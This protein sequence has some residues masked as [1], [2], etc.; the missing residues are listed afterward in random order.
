MSPPDYGTEGPL[1]CGMTTLEPARDNGQNSIRVGDHGQVQRFRREQALLTMAKTAMAGHT[2][3]VAD[4]TEGF[5]GVLGVRDAS[6]PKSI[7]QPSL[8]GYNELLKNPIN[9][10]ARGVRGWSD[11]PPKHRR[12]DTTWA[13]FT[14]MKAD[15]S[16]KALGSWLHGRGSK[17]LF[18][19]DLTANVYGDVNA[20]AAQGDCA[21]TVYGDVKA[22]AA[23]GDCAANVHGDAKAAVAQGSCAASVYGDVNAAAAARNGEQHYLSRTW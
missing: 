7:A 12:A 3:A 8:S 15:G 9:V 1:H 21:A 16:I 10:E 13:D 17:Q 20:V 6:E 22:A 5:P 11:L 19:V 18:G 4:T 23:Q 14:E 2:L